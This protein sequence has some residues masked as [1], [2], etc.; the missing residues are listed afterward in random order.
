MPLRDLRDGDTEYLANNLKA[1]DRA[2]LRALSDEDFLSIVEKSVRGSDWVKVGALAD[3]TPACVFGVA[4]TG[5]DGVGIPWLLGTPAITKVA[6]EFLR[7]NRA[8]VKDMNAKYPL[9][10]NYV[11]TENRDAI[12]WLRWLGFTFLNKR[13]LGRAGQEF[14]EFIRLESADV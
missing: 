2:E 14:Y 8:V 5:L 13:P 6:V 10:V 12:R 7:A 4:A 11:H 1:E 3:D 9:L